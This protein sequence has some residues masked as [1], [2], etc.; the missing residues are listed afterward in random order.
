MQTINQENPETVLIEKQ[1]NVSLDSLEQQQK[2]TEETEQETETTNV[3]KRNLRKRKNVSD[4]TIFDNNDNDNDNIETPK[5]SNIN[6]K[7]RLRSAKH[8]KNVQETPTEKGDSTKIDIDLPL[9][10]TNQQQFEITSVD[11]T[12]QNETN[13]DSMEKEIFSKPADRRPLNTIHRRNLQDSFI[14]QSPQLQD[15][16]ISTTQMSE[17]AQFT[18]PPPQQNWK[19]ANIVEKT[20]KTFNGAFKAII[21]SSTNTNDGNN[22]TF[23]ME[24]QTNDPKM[25][26]DSI[27]SA[28]T[29]LSI[30]RKMVFLVCIFLC[31][32]SF[33]DKIFIV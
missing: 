28:E 23:G 18:T 31:F 32:F 21:N 17:I 20:K 2:Q 4:D 8:R 7:K 25:I 33:Y 26:E 16:S 14:N 10:E 11:V 29:P 22:N 1:N 19:S 12:K 15:H 13:I 24:I 6:I 30:Q 27:S 5:I 3:K 9:N